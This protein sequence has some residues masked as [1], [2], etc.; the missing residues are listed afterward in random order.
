MV[1]ATA[2]AI[3]LPAQNDKLIFSSAH[4]QPITFMVG[5]DPENLV[6]HSRDLPKGSTQL[7]IQNRMCGDWYVEITGPRHV[8]ATAPLR[9]DAFLKVAALARGES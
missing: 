4:V 7:M 1:E 6:E 9:I 5:D 3:A 2:R 8:C